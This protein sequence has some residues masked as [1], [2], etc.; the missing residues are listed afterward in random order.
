MKTPVCAFCVN[1]AACFGYGEGQ[2]RK[3]YAC[4]DCCGHGCEDGKCIPVAQHLAAI[5]TRHESKQ[6]RERKLIDRLYRAYRDLAEEAEEPVKPLSV[7][8]DEFKQK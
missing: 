5:I 4:N 3:E 7:W 2:R 1:D 6:R 8:R